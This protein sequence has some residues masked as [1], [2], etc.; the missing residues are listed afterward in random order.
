M[1]LVLKFSSDFHDFLEIFKVFQ[2][3]SL[4]GEFS[5]KK[6]SFPLQSISGAEQNQKTVDRAN[7]LAHLLSW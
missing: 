7:F 1:K 2:F 4:G 6:S 5:L 3:K